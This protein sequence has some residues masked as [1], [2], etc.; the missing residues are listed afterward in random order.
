MS[1]KNRFDY[2]D[3]ME[4]TAKDGCEI[5]ILGLIKCLQG[6]CAGENYTEENVLIK[7]IPTEPIKV[8]DL[9]I[10]ASKKRTNCMTGKEYDK[11]IF[12]K[13]KLNQIAE[14]LLI[15]RN[16]NGEAEKDE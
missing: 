4:K 12:D 1:N 11:Y 2:S 10:N 5:Y 6:L 7:F 15:Y 16:H 14:Y 3:G 8:A 13:W 9:L